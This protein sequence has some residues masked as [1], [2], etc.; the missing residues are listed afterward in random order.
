MK[1]DSSIKREALLGEEGGEDFATNA[2]VEAFPRAV[3]QER[4]DL[5]NHA[6]VHSA[7]VGPFRRILPH[8]A[9]GVFI[10]ATL[11]STIGAREVNR[12][13]QGRGQE[14]KFRESLAVVKG[15]RATK[16]LEQRPESL[17]AGL[18]HRMASHVL[19]ASQQR[20]TGLAFHSDASPLR[21]PELTSISPSQSPK[22]ARRSTTLGRPSIDTAWGNRPGFSDR[23]RLEHRMGGAWWNVPYAE[24]AGEKVESP[25]KSTRNDNQLPIH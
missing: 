6:V 7:R 2:V 15:H 3:T 1:A 24:I 10:G 8:Q 21:R 12:R 16:N 4:F 5:G 9:I 13:P 18:S 11:P 17:P 22:R 14:G 19:N 20:V 25:I 23:L